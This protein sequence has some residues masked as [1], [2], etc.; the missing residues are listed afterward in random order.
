MAQRKR[1]ATTGGATIALDA[2]TYYYFRD[3]VIE[4]L[5]RD[6][7]L[8][9]LEFG[10]AVTMDSDG[11]TRTWMSEGIP[12]S[13]QES[14]VS[15]LWDTLCSTDRLVG[16]NLL[17]FDLPLLYFETVLAAR[18]RPGWPTAM[19]IDLFAA[20]R[21]ATGRA[22]PLQDVAYATLGRGKS[23]SLPQ[24][25]EWL[26]Q[27][28]T[29]RVADYCALDVALSRDLYAHILTGEP[30]ILP[31]RETYEENHGFRL[32]LDDRGHWQR[33]EPIF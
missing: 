26:R 20:I 33:L 13:T 28:E 23:T 5:P 6:A 22:Y 17:A 11:N 32:W 10:L 2:V 1:S 29:Q 15:A 3:E 12:G 27:G 19:I 16:Y 21:N 18:Q 31:R 7:Q 4:A 30:L 9:M 24:S 14:S 8:M 25:A